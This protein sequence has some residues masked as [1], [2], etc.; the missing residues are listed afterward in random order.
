ME[1]LCLA[2]KPVVM[3]ELKDITQLPLDI[4]ELYR[5][6]QT[7][8]NG[9]GILPTVIKVSTLAGEVHKTAVLG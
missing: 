4:S 7:L 1:D 9:V 6:L 5:K 8:N 3:A 2:E